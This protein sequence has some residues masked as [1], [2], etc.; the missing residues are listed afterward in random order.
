MADRIPISQSMLAPDGIFCAAIDDV[1]ASNLRQLLQNLFGKEN[2]LAVVAVCSNPAGRQRPTGFAPAHAYAMFFALTGKAQVGRFERTEEQLESAEID[3]QDR[4]FTWRGLRNGGGPNALRGARL[5]LF[6]PLF[7][8]GEQIRIPS[9]EW[10][11]ETRQWQLLESPAPGEVE[12][13]PIRPDGEEMT[14][15]YGVETLQG[16]LSETIVRTDRNGN[17]R[18]D[19]RRYLNMEGMLPKTWWDKT[20]YSSTQYGSIFLTNMLGD[21]LAF[22]F[23]KSIHLVEDCLRVSSLGK[24]D[25][26]LDYFGG[27]GTTAHATINLNRQDSGNRKYILVEMGHHFNN[28]L[29]PRIKKAIY[30]EKW[31]N[32]KPVSRDSRLSHMIKYQ[33]LESY[34]DALNNIAF[35][36]TEN[37]NQLLDQHHLS[38]LLGSETRESQTFLNIDNLQNPFTY[39]LKSS[40]PDKGV[41]IPETF[42]Y[43]LGLKVQNRQCLYDNDRRYLVYRGTTRQKNVVIIWRTTQN[44]QPQDWKR[45]YKFIKEKE[46]IKNADEVYI[47]TDSIVPNAKPIDPLFKR[48]MFTNTATP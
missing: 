5:R 37:E 22:M 27:S 12:V 25:T 31:K 18:I 13:L 48:L 43:L 21:S 40:L 26:V 9:M 20:E 45:D 1:E 33:R 28:V 47:N 24:N 30:A 19:V 15:R 32:A 6:Y 44:W 14:W 23:P 16:R 46:L 42:N 29:M 3:E 41:D 2:E 11:I 7:V 8:E 4:Y 17:I 38:Y 36:P 35:T 10:N 39:Q 34:E